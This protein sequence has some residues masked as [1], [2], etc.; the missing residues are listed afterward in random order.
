MLDLNG[1]VTVDIIN[2][3]NEY[4][5]M[6]LKDKNMF[7]TPE[8]LALYEQKYIE[9][10]K[11]KSLC[12]KAYGIE[13]Y[14]PAPTYM[15][16][17]IIRM[18]EGSGVVPVQFSPMHSLVTCVM[19][20][21]F[22]SKCPRIEQH[23]VKVLPTTLYYYI[24]RYSEVFGKFSELQKVPAKQLMDDIVKEAIMLDAADIT[25]ST[26]GNYCNVY[27]NV[28]K[29]LVHSNRILSEEDMLGVIKYLCIRSPMDDTSY[30]PKYVGVDLNEMYRGRVV[31]NHK[32]KGYAITIRMIS[33]M[34]FDKD[35]KSLNLSENVIDFLITEMLNREP[36]MRVIS[37][38]TMSGKN[39]TI[40][41]LLKLLIEKDAFKVVS[42]EM[43]VEQELHGVEQIQCDTASEYKESIHSLIRQNP[44]YVYVTEMGDETGKDVVVVT[45]TGKCV[46]TTVHA[47]SAIDTIDRLVDITGYTVDRVIQTVHSICYQELVRDD[48]T[49]T[50]RPMNR[51]IRLDLQRKLQLYGKSH[52]DMILQ[53]KEWEEG[54]VW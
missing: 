53:L 31:I 34:A 16:D 43:P 4:I 52:G 10:D 46:F 23:D 20:P 6:R 48:A 5:D 12:E 38:A 25:I 3:V 22:N 2:E 11:I 9:R 32:F 15:P 33:K 17:Y 1:V 36:G 41:A 42:V 35:L 44:D 8:A 18:F 7:T 37:G 29:K 40:L 30:K 45:N 21:E 13:L 47:N 26:K 14:E 50:V 54:D 49:D 51:Y 19:L 24:E 39:T 28:R 27:Y